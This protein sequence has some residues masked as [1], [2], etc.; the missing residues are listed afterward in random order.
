[1][2]VEAVVTLGW[3]M[4]NSKWIQEN[5]V[6]EKAYISIL[7]LRAPLVEDRVGCVVK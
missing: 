1:M 4:F 5:I 6:L 2:V 7:G 3:T